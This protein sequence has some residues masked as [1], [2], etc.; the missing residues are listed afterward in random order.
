[1]SFAWRTLNYNIVKSLEMVMV[2]IR[3]DDDDHY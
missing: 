1:M 3:D 2:M